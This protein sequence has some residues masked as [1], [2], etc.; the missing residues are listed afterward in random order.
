ML[1]LLFN[2][3]NIIV[4]LFVLFKLKLSIILPTVIVSHAGIL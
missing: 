2:I 1:L 4:Y 3:F